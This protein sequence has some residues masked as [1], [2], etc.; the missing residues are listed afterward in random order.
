MRSAFPIQLSRSSDAGRSCSRPRPG[1]RRCSSWAAR[2]RAWPRTP[3]PRC[4]STSARPA[5]IRPPSACRPARSCSRSPTWAV[6]SPS[7]RSSRATSWWTR[8]RTS[9]PR[10]RTTSSP[11][12]T[13]ASTPRSAIRSSHPRG[14]LS[15]TGGRGRQP[16]AVDGRGQRHARRPTRPSTRRTSGPR[17]PISRRGSPTFVAAIKAGDL[18]TARSLYATD[19]RALGDHRAHRG[20]VRGPRPRHRLPGRRTSRASTIR[21]GP[22]STASSGSCGW[23][24]RRAT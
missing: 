4:R 10:S 24:A 15:V 3:R 16:A 17:P 11:V 19:P 23:P 2:C 12:W 1:A 6:T 14:T 20:A 18:D 13:A 9:C 7:S 5:A 21:P 8:S 22:A